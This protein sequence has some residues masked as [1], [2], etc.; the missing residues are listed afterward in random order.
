M[1]RPRLRFWRTGALFELV[2]PWRCV[3]A[4]QCAT[5]THWRTGALDR[6]PCA[7]ALA[8]HCGALAHW[9]S[10]RSFGLSFRPWRARQVTLLSG[11]DRHR[12]LAARV[13]DG[14][15][16]RPVRPVC[17][18]HEPSADGFADSSAEVFPRV[19]PGERVFDCATTERFVSAGDDIDH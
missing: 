18:L 3:R 14:V 17:D 1:S 9:R 15:Q 13:C 11:R 19:V 8:A 7:G 10:R 6:S 4:V 5:Y 12:A 16:L 2:L